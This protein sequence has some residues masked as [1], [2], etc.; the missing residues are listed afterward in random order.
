MP[1]DCTGVQK[2]AL[3]GQTGVIMHSCRAALSTTPPPPATH[4]HHSCR[5]DLACR[6]HRHNCHDS[7][8]ASGRGVFL[9]A[10]RRPAIHHNVSHPPSCGCKA[11]T[12]FFLDTHSYTYTHVRWP[13]FSSRSLSLSVSVSVSL[14]LSL[15]VSVSLSPCISLSSSPQLSHSHTHARTHARTHAH[16]HTH[17]HER[18]HARTHTHT[19][20]HARTHART[21]LVH[22]YIAEN[23]W[24]RPS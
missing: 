16:T 20:T 5:L 9:A 13:H 2:T 12:I 18:T 1:T 15:S 23:K 22:I 14:F 6:R 24:N 10:R 7:G 21:P 3:T 19:R 4:T 8:Q 17:T 11:D